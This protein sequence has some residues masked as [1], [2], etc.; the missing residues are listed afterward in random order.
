M[1]KYFLKSEVP[2]VQILEQKSKLKSCKL[3]LTYDS[4]TKLVKSSLVKD[5]GSHDDLN[6][7]CLQ[8][9]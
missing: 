6:N 5:L 9:L 3:R 8:G 2:E 7:T 1:L 4:F